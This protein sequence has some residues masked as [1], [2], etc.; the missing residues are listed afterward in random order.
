MSVSQTI[1]LSGRGDMGSLTDRLV[2]PRFF[3]TTQVY[4]LSALRVT[5]AGGSGSNPLYLKVD[6]RHGPPFDR[7]IQTFTGVGTGGL[8][9]EFRIDEDERDTFRFH[10]DPDWLTRDELVLIWTDPDAGKLTTWS[11]SVDLRDDS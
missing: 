4:T 8:N 1:S 5:F 2:P 9:I 7:I 6:H 10:Y 3:L 11:V